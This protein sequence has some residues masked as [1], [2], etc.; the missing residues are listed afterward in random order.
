MPGQGRLGD[1]A[2]VPLDAH[3]CPA[4]PHPAIGP[5]I[6][7]SPD[8]NVNR[9]PALRVGDPGIHA[10]CCGTNT[11]TATKGSTTVF[12]NGKSAH[13]MGDQNRHCGGMGQLVEGSPNVIVGEPG[14][15]GNSEFGIGGG[16]SGGLGRS[17]SST[18][19]DNSSGGG[20]GTGGQLALGSSGD[21]VQVGVG[22]SAPSVDPNKTFIE[23]ELVDT[24]GLPVA[25]A[26]YSVTASDGTVFSGTLDAD[27]H[28]YIEGVTKGSCKMTFPDFHGNDWS[29]A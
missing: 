4:C 3:G 9:R 8:V 24:D 10:A 27:G 29:A 12:I 28:I 1:K 25:F 16:G 7:G 14:G 18:G 23:L 5:A 2:N 19:A 26:G 21:P 13:R 17:S 15:G 11:W 22:A 20:A 6:Q